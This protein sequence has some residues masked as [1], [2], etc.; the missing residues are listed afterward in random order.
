MN[1]VKVVTTYLGPDVAKELR[2]IVQQEKVVRHIPIQTHVS[3]DP[4]EERA[5]TVFSWSRLNYDACD[6]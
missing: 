5:G 2:D 1:K 6:S 3:W 4:I